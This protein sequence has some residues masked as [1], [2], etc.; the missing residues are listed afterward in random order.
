MPNRDIHL[1]NDAARDVFAAAGEGAGAPA[2]PNR[3]ADIQEPLNDVSGAARI[4]NPCRRAF[5][6]G[7]TGQD[8]QHLAE[9]LHEQGYDVYGMVKGQNNP[10]AAAVVE[11]MPFVELVAGDLADLPS[12]VAALE[13]AQPD[14]VY[15]L[16]AIRFVALSLLAGRADGEHHGARRA[17]DARG[18]PHGGRDAEQPD[19]LLPGVVVGDVR[20]GAGDPA[21]RADAVPSTLAVR[22]RQG[23]RSRHHGQLPRVVRAVRLLGDPVQPRRAA[24]GH[25]VR[26]PQGLERRGSHQA[27]PAARAGDGHARHQA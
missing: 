13:V 12:L 2:V 14:E 7:I 26:H 20:Q 8:G 17:A 23:V 19:S 27:R 15:N 9:F 6:T 10:K 22:L 5:I 4:R 21:E 25:R 24:P 3:L 11:E 18:D 1:R 16:G